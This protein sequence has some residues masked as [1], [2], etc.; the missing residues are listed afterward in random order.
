M[1]LVNLQHDRQ[2][3]SLIPSFLSQESY[4]RV[5]GNSKATMMSAV[6]FCNYFCLLTLVQPVASF[7]VSLH[8]PSASSGEQKTHSL[9][10]GHVCLRASQEHHKDAHLKDVPSW[11]EKY[12]YF[13][14]GPFPNGG[15]FSS[16]CLSHRP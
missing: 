15:F 14:S 6:E 1:E 9:P 5:T 2:I 7:K 12:S 11:K 13:S 4:E 10:M 16:I 8:R 3:P